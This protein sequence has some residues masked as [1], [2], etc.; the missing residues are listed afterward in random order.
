[1]KIRI[2]YYF[3]HCYKTLALPDRDCCNLC[4][5]QSLQSEPIRKRLHIW[6]LISRTLD[7]LALT[8]G[9]RH[10]TL[11]KRTPLNKLIV[12]IVFLGLLFFCLLYC[13]TSAVSS[14][15]SKSRFLS[16]IMS[17]TVRV[18]FYPRCFPTSPFLKP[19]FM[20]GCVELL[21]RLQLEINCLDGKKIKFEIIEVIASHTHT[22]RRQ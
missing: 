1:M 7:S 17:I 12:S 6:I 15:R 21:Q 18:I 3:N 5:S 11:N 14:T 16:T 22:C 10:S 4:R 13:C 19:I 20:S 2:L 8:S 9:R